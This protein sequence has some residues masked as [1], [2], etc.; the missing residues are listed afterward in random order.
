M[1]EALRLSYFVGGFCLIA[2][3]AVLGSLVFT[4]DDLWIDFCAALF[5]LKPRELSFKDEFRLRNLKQKRIAIMVA[6]WQEHQIIERM[7]EGNI[8]QIEYQSYS[9]F[10]GVYPNDHKTLEVALRLQREHSNVIVVIN[11]KNGATT[12]GQMLNEIVRTILNAE[13]ATGLTYDLFLMQDSEDVLHPLLLQVINEA[14]LTADFVQTPVFSFDVPFTGWTRGT[15]L[16]EFSEGHTKDL[17]VRERLGAAIPSAGVGTALSRRLVLAYTFRTGGR[18]LREDTLTEDY[19]L[20]LRTKA[21]GLKS[22]FVCCYRTDLNGNRDF[23]ATR[24]FFPSTVKASIRQKTRWTLGIA[25]QGR[26]NLGW[27][28]EWIDRYFFFRDRRGP[29]NGIVMILGLITLAG[30]LLSMLGLFDLPT[31]LH[32]SLFVILAA[33]NGFNMFVRV[34]QRARCVA[35]VHSAKHVWAVPI[36]WPVGM[37]INA[38]ASF[39]AFKNYHLAKRAGEV[40][41]WE[42]TAHELPASFGVILPQAKLYNEISFSQTSTE[43]TLARQSF[44][45]TSNFSKIQPFAISQSIVQSM[46]QSN[47]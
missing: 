44:A 20:G 18:L 46:E 40:P 8:A 35:R 23:V 5:R 21:L 45:T 26:D 1:W 47:L 3:L 9:F 11:S 30:F 6:S 4:I 43:T 38:M 24:E 27:D 7:V 25:F 37:W 33:L 32:S 16:E 12:K 15:Y 42:K 34:I 36:R 31:L 41:R 14:S 2:I 22:K 28:G 17:L 39:H 19:D 13:R 29:L 10:L